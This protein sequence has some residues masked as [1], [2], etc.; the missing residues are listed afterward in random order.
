MHNVTYTQIL[1]AYF[2]HIL[3]QVCHLQGEQNASVKNQMPMISCQLQGL[4][5]CNGFVVDF[6]EV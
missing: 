5:V 2:Q 6:D 3:V 4:T 1:K